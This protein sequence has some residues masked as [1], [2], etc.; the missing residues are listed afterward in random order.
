MHANGVRPVLL[1]EINEV[2]WRLIDRYLMRPRFVNLRSFFGRA[3][4]YTTTTVDE[5][6]LSPWVTWPTVHRGVSSN[7]H[8][9]RNLGQ[10]PSTFAGTSIWEE[11]RRKGL[12]IGICGSLQSWPPIDPG[13]DGF[14]IP[15]TFARD[16]R[17]VPS[18]LE[19]LQRF[20]L[21]QVRSN[22]RVV[23]RSIPMTRD[24]GRL[25]VS[26]PSTGI[27][28]QTVLKAGMQLYR[29]RVDRRYSARRSVFQ[30]MI[31]WDVF[32]KLYRPL[33][34][35]SF[36]T[37]FTNHIAGVMHRY[38][39]H[40]F[41]EDF[42]ADRRGDGFHSNTMDFSMAIL[43]EILGDVLEFV[44]LNPELAVAF[45]TSMGQAAVV[46]HHEGYAASI[47]DVGTLMKLFGLRPADFTPLLAMVPQVAVE[48]P[49][50]DHRFQIR[51]ALT[52]CVTTS[53]RDLFSIQELNT[54]LSL[55]VFTPPKEDVVAGGLHFGERFVPW[56]EAGIQMNEVDPGTAY[57]IPEGIFA[58]L[59]R[60]LEADDARECIGAD[61]V[62]NMLLGYSEGSGIS[63][64]RR[65]GVHVTDGV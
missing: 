23:S 55:T 48:I 33:R 9:I 16:A 28:L 1:L 4:T 5:G 3:R 46:R 38:W 53:G 25:L 15:D 51:T 40:I 57:H 13:P 10:D 61:Q 29:E 31:F 43:E 17:C 32:R 56:S 63:E 22:G 27:R 64:I 12:S 26:L 2:P 11:V 14:Y 44:R 7:V 24:A 30:A 50:D 6:E 65:Q 21:S 60:D 18:S 19:P 8:R 54:T 45:A 59:D 58:I 35:P 39:N 20:N 36:A 37:F 47:S 34:P 52:R 49:R 62:R 41:P 42:P